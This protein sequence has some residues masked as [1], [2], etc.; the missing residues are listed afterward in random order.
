DFLFV[1]NGILKRSHF[2]AVECDGHEFHERNKEQAARD[3]SRDRWLAQGRIPVMRFTGSE[4][5]RDATAC[6]MEVHEYL[7]N[8][9]MEDLEEWNR[10]VSAA[11]LESLV[12]CN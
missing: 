4:I 7:S 10:T 6:A 12:A 5:N 9:F 2:L 8:R 1:T 11:D 3:K